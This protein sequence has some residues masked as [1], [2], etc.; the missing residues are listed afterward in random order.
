MSDSSVSQED[1]LDACLGLAFGSEQGSSCLMN[2]QSVLQS[3]GDLVQTVPQVLL[4][5]SNEKDAADPIVVRPDVA[6][7]FKQDATRYRIDGEIAEGGMGKI[8]KGRD[9]DLG[10]DLAVK[11]LLDR[12][13][14]KPEVIQRFIEEAQIGGQLQHPGIAPVY[15][16]GQFADQRPFFTMKLVKGKTLAAL[17]GGR[18]DVNVDHSKFLGIFEQICQT[19]AYAHSRGVIHRDL[20][21]ANIMVG[22]FGEVQVMD[23]GLAK[24]LSSGGVADERKANAT[25]QDLSVIE[26]LRSGGSDTPTGFGSQTRIGSVMGTPAY[27]PPEQALGEIDQLDE[28]ADVFG[29]GAILC[30]ILTGKPPCV[31]EDAVKIFR[32]ASRGKL[33]ECFDRLD[34]CSAD[35]ELISLTKESLASE[36]TDRPSDAGVLAE[37]I[38][39][40]QD[41]I[42]QRLRKSEID[43]AA[44]TVRAN[45][46]R[47]RRRVSL[48]LAATTLL[49]VASVLGGGLLMQAQEAKAQEKFAAAAQKGAEQQT[50]LAA[51]ATKLADQKGKPR[52]NSDGND[53]NPICF[54]LR[55]KLPKVTSRLAKKF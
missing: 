25:H 18:K 19:V 13:I 27:M 23:W 7:Q 6:K 17:L 28:R 35:P 32:M 33:D 16:L 51:A 20:K 40:H 52:N 11:V 44:A 50:K 47:K 14:N 10:R 12:H 54:G 2:H 4:R 45:E 9:T 36:P 15:E 31:A 3:L 22:A 1:S 53:I 48:A 26:T 24:V 21:P 49:L 29:L 42:E 43:R 46:E 38:A 39:E 5:D 8:L 34:A 55:R 30:E 37:R 41:A